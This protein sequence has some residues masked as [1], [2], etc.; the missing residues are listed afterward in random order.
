MSA[1]RLNMDLGLTLF[2]NIYYECWKLFKAAFVFSTSS[3]PIKSNLFI[4]I[5]EVKTIEVKESYA[6]AVA[7][8]D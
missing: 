7:T 8:A 2:R 1:E 4:L 5:V 6:A 3:K